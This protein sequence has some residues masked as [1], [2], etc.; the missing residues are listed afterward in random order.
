M[1]LIPYPEFKDFFIALN[2]Q[3]VYGSQPIEGAACLSMNSLPNCVKDIIVACRCCFRYSTDDGTVH[4]VLLFEEVQRNATP[5]ED[6]GVPEGDYEFP[7]SFRCPETLPPST[8]ISGG[9]DAVANCKKASA[10]FYRISASSVVQPGDSPSCFKFCPSARDSSSAGSLDSDVYISGSPIRIS[11]FIRHELLR[12]IN[13]IK[14]NIRQNLKVKKRSMRQVREFCSSQILATKV[15]TENIPIKR[16]QEYR[17]DIIMNLKHEDRGKLRGVALSGQMDASGGPQ[18][19]SSVRL[20]TPEGVEV[21]YCVEVHCCVFFSPN[22]I[23]TLPFNVADR[24]ADEPPPD[25][26]PKTPPYSLPALP[27]TYDY[28]EDSETG[29]PSYDDAIRRRSLYKIVDGSASQERLKSVVDAFSLQKSMIASPLP[30]DSTLPA[31]QRL[32]L[33]ASQ[34]STS[35]STKTLQ[36]P[37]GGRLL[38]SVTLQP[39]DGHITDFVKGSY[40]I[41]GSEQQSPNASR[42]NSPKL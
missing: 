41:K 42:T 19:A 37:Q 38:R 5:F 2:K 32:R 31:W 6:D 11:L 14:I 9:W 34:S 7:F 12:S 40:N 20:F 10:Y 35:L 30:W 17:K 18:L 15:L 1:P 26:W 36:E 23:I 13:T 4:T 16:H 24:I 3:I 28:D 22:Y 33:S 39:C 27:E 21:S 25:Y 29:V 8:T